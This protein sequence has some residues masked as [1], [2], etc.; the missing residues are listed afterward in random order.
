MNSSP[1]KNA[2]ASPS[3]L[4]WTAYSIRIPHC[5]PSPRSVRNAAESCGVVM[6]RMSRMPASI[7]V[8]SG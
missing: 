1:I 2:C 5:A 8:V 6:I 7:S 4:G 3:G